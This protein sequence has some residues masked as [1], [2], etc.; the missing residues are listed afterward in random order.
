MINDLISFLNDS[1]VNFLAV[2]TLS[3]RLEA[4]GFRHLN[5]CQ[6][7]GEIPAGSKLFVTK[8]DS[9]L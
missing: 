2:N 3:T 5:A 1:P 4:A 6:P 9:S 7:L 8:N